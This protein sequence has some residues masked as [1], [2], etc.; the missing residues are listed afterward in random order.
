MFETFSAVMSD[1]AGIAQ[2]KEEPAAKLLPNFRIE[3]FPK[4]IDRRM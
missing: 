4:V 1:S 3:T 2:A